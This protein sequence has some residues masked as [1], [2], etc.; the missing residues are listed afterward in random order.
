MS[1]SAVGNSSASSINPDSSNSN[2]AN[3][4]AAIASN[5]V[6]NLDTSGDGKV[7]KDEFVQ[8]LTSKGVSSTDA[9]KMFDSIDKNKTGSITKS[10]ISSAI[11]S[12]TIALPQ[13]PQGG[14]G[15]PKGTSA[16]PQRGGSAGSG[17]SSIVELSSAASSK[18]TSGTSSSS[19]SSK[20]YAKADANQDGVVTNV[21]QMVYD[22]SH[23]SLPST[24]ATGNGSTSNSANSQSA[25]NTG[26][27][28][29]VKI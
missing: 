6:S 11:Q 12:G 21:E 2:M 16:P 20:N 29:D 27:N 19:S 25:Q 22:L 13:P 26:K 28:V 5:M 24:S 23:P 4:A 18:S 15:G 14:A 10:D 3:M 9:T 8:G 17:S 7:S 1:I